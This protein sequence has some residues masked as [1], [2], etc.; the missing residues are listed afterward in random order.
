MVTY[1]FDL[2]DEPWIPV[3]TRDGFE[4]VSLRAAL[5]RAPD[6]I[7]LASEHSVLD[8]VLLRHPLLPIVFD[9]TGVPRTVGEWKDRW[10]QGRLD[11]GRIDS[12]L[13]EHRDRFDLFHPETPFAQVAGLTTRNRSTKPVSVLLPSEAVG[14]NVPLFS[15][16]TEADPPELDPASA[17]RWLLHAHV[18]DTGGIKSGAD[19]DPRASSGKTTGN[20]PGPLGQIGPVVPLGRSLFETLMLNISIIPD[21]LRPDD[22]PH[23]RRTPERADWEIRPPAGILDLFT[24]LSRRVRLVPSEVG[25]GVVVRE[26]IVT[27]GDRLASVPLDLEPHTQWRQQVAVDDAGDAPP[28]RPLRH[29]AGRAMWQGLSSLIAL[30]PDANSRQTSS[31]LAQLGELQGRGALPADYPLNVQI[32]GYEYGTQDAVVESAIADVIPLPVVALLADT[33]TRELIDDLASSASGLINAV[34]ILQ[35]DLRRASGGEPVPWDKGARPGPSLVHDLDPIVR[36]VLAG[37]SKEPERTDD[38]AKA[39]CELADAAARRAGERLVDGCP[40]SALTGRE[41]AR[42]KRTIA[43][44]APIALLRFRRRVREA[45]APLEPVDDEPAT[46]GEAMA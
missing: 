45:L 46:Y 40:P 37:L 27:A 10:A 19:G 6:I 13:D 44:R 14:N 12:Y 34:D 18:F 3:S 42:G 22:A 17:A 24:W 31:L 38:A 39:W 15:A 4:E 30:S 32:A 9:A 25:S 2:I 21:G 5:Q 29:Q 8:V 43:H 26:A 11:V 23:W 7:G 41:E 28:M 16:R 1:S 20:K 35:A 33:S 36:R